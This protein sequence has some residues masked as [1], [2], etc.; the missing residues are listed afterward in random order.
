MPVQNAPLARMTARPHRRSRIDRLSTAL[1]VPLLVWAI[2]AEPATAARPDGQLVLTIVDEATGEPLAARMT[3]RNPRGRPVVTRGVGVASLGDH[4]YVDSAVTLALRRGQYTFD[5]DAGPEYH[6]Q[7]GHFEILRRSDDATE[8]RMRRAVDL[9]NEGWV[10][11]DLDAPR[12]LTGLETAMRAE[13]LGYK[14]HLAWREAKGRWENVSDQLRRA[15]RGH[16]QHGVIGDD[17]LIFYRPAPTLAV[18]DLHT[19]DRVDAARLVELK[20]EGWRVVAADLTDWRLPIW[21]AYDALD[22]AMVL[23]A[24]SLAEREPRTTTGPAR[25]TTFYPGVRGLG[26]WRE[27]IYFHVL[28]AGLR[29]PPVAGSG[30]GENELPLGSARV[31]AWTD[32]DDSPEA[33]WNAVADGAT[34]VTTGP[35]LRPT[36]GGRR[37]GH[38]FY[39]DSSLDVGGDV[40]GDAGGGADF[41][42]ALSLT[43][44]EPI[45]YLELLQNGEVSAT[46]ALRDVAASGGRLPPLTFDGPGWFAVRAVTPSETN[47]RRAMSA[48]FY[49]TADGT[50]RISAKSC[51]FFLDWLDQIGDQASAGEI[52]AAKAFWTKRLAGANAR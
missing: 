22:A 27:K 31:Y 49:V 23:D 2:G 48:P 5:L 21:L 3:L 20:Q 19:I 34:F 39:V 37:P 33:W 6:P 26:R 43:T 28:G 50:P 16:L 51:R 18:A 13:R 15:D 46:V 52:E 8:V 42:I 12:Q 36:V 7:Q 9:A 38:V 45:E 35:L 32:G 4:F 17:G 25:D 40:V 10:G 29:L 24:A 14:A 47:Y 41:Q 1:L 11:A 30:S 44:R